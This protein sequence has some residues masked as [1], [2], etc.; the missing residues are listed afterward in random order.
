MP[1]RFH[2]DGFYY[3]GLRHLF[4]HAGNG[5]FIQR[6]VRLLE[7]SLMTQ[8]A[9][10]CSLLQ[11]STCKGSTSADTIEYLSQSEQ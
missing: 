4:G 7:F 10:P 1:S 3:P 6:G 11:K 2:V 8:E 5:C 9:A